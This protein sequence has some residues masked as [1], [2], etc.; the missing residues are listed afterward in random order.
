MLLAAQ[1]SRQSALVETAIEDR[2][3]SLA[4]QEPLEKL[5]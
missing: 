1:I 4:R 3:E 2:E 5:G